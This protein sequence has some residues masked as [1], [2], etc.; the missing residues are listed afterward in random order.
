[1]SFVVVSRLGLGRRLCGRM[2]REV[3]VEAGAE[4]GYSL[5]DIF[6]KSGDDGA[7]VFAACGLVMG[8]EV[9]PYHD[10][11]LDIAKFQFHRDTTDNGTALDFLEVIEMPVQ[12]KI[13]TNIASESVN[14]VIAAGSAE[15]P[16]HNFRDHLGGRLGPFLILVGAHAFAARAVDDLVLAIESGCGDAANQ[17]RDRKSVGIG[18]ESGIRGNR[19]LVILAGTS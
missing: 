7:S 9:R 8:V 19:E 3:L 1:M 16:Q 6:V 11:R 5:L 10:A 17:Q 12:K 18:G 15:L 13:S 14:A 2:L 4:F